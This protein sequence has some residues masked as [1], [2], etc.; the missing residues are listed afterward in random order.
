MSHVEDSGRKGWCVGYFFI[1]LILFAML[2]AK[3]FNYGSQL[4]FD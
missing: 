4:N 2:V 3:L 1:S